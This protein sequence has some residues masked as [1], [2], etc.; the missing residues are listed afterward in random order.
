MEELGKYT[1]VLQWHGS[2][3]ISIRQNIKR[4]GGSLSAVPKG[5]SGLPQHCSFTFPW[6][7]HGTCLLEVR[8]EHE[9]AFK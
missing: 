6:V 2:S 3:S 1:E 5:F 4:E 9:Q 8:G 7:I